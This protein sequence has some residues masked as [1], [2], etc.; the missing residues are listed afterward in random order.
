MPALK[1]VDAKIE[2]ARSE[3]RLLKAD[4]AAFC[5][6]RA[7]LIVREEWDNGRERWVYRGD[8]PKAPIQWSIR[9]GEFAYNL[10]S[11]LDHI[12]W[13]LVEVNGGRPNTRNQFPIQ[14][15]P[16]EDDFSQKTRGVSQPATDYMELVQ[17]YQRSKQPYSPD[18]ERVG[19]GLAILNEL[20]N[21]DTH[22]HLA[23]AN[24]CWTGKPPKR[25]KL[26]DHEATSYVTDITA[27]KPKGLQHGQAI[28]LTRGYK[29]WQYLEFPIDAFF[30]G[31]QDAG[32]PKE[33]PLSVAETLDACIDSVEMVVG[34]L[35]KEFD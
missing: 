17:P 29:D 9:A 15:N 30:E 33:R 4:I 20:R 18:Y 6:E 34:H 8:T 32:S 1:A 24:A 28:A 26:A 35:R 14:N 25:R 31:L 13:R 7:R 27:E 21:I 3:L 12:V 10:R 22:R 5:E 16:N 11:A 23:I 2:R 19:K